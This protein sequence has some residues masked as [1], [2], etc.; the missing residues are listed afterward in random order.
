MDSSINASVYHISKGIGMLRRMKLYVATFARTQIYNDIILPHLDYCSLVWD[1]CNNYLIKKLHKM[2]NRA[3]R[4][5]T[6]KLYETR[7][8]EILADL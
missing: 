4:F 8:S 5:I 7:S 6:G 3:A 1:T 2:Q